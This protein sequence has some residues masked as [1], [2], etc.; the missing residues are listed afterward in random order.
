MAEGAAHSLLGSKGLWVS[1]VP[2]NGRLFSIMLNH[3][4]QCGV[5]SCRKMGYG[6]S[7]RSNK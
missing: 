1:I 5:R 6:Y 2:E 3:C 7:S 4:N